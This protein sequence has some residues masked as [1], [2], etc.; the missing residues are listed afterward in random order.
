MRNIERDYQKVGA[1][2]NNQGNRLEHL[3]TLYNLVDRFGILYP[4]TNQYY[5]L[6]YNYNLIVKTL[7]YGK[8]KQATGGDPAEATR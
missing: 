8:I 2:L 4:L 5:N 3:P 6:I 1:A 7:N